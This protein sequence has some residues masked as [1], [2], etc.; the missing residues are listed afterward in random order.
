MCFVSHSYAM[1]SIAIYLF[2]NVSF[3]AVVLYVTFISATTILF[4]AEPLIYEL[5]CELTFPIGEGTTNSIL[6]LVN[7]IFGFVFLLIP[8]LPNIGKYFNTPP[9]CS[10]VLKML[11]IKTMTFT[12]HT[13]QSHQNRIQILAIAKQNSDCITLRVTLE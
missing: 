6:T 7:N 11:W 4:C 13:Y 8:T 12:F 2:V 10:N 1:E 3:F 5:T 9:V